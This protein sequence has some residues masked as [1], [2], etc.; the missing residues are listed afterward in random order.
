MPTRSIEQNRLDPSGAIFDEIGSAIARVGGQITVD[1]ARALTRI[2]VALG[3]EGLDLLGRFQA[4][5]AADDLRLPPI[6]SDRML[7][8][9]LASFLASRTRSTDVDAPP[10]ALE[11]ETK[12]AALIQGV[13]HA[14]DQIQ[15]NCRALADS[16][17]LNAGALN[18]RTA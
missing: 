10:E 17:V 16:A 6:R 18:R 3:D 11:R 15:T 2:D 8:R 9:A 7:P 5:H 4:E 12:L 13:L 1:D 14:Y